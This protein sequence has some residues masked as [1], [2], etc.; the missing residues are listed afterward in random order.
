LSTKILFVLMTALAATGPAVANMVMIEADDYSIALNVELVMNDSQEIETGSLTYPLVVR[1]SVW[2]GDVASATSYSRQ[3]FSIGSASENLKDVPHDILTLESNVGIQL[4]TYPAPPEGGLN[5]TPFGLGG[6]VENLTITFVKNVTVGWINPIQTPMY[7]EEW[8]YGD[9]TDLPDVYFVL[10]AVDDV[11]T[12]RMESIYG[13]SGDE[14]SAEEFE[15]FL[16]NVDVLLN[17]PSAGYPIMNET[18]NH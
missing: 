3:T 1:G 16:K 15:E 17:V 13:V 7:R 4:D 14:M 9:G 8:D 11:T 2:P 18:V 5:T 10:F 6:E 12:C